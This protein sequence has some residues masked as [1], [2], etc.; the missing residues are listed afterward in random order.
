MR[1]TVRLLSYL[2]GLALACVLA[3]AVLIVWRVPERTPAVEKP[4]VMR[5]AD[6]GFSSRLLGRNDLMAAL[7]GQPVSLSLTGDEIDAV[8]QDLAR[9]MLAGAGDVS[10]DDGE[11]AVILSM[12]LKRTPLRV[13]AFRGEWLNLRAQVRAE[14][15][16]LPRLVSVRLGRLPVPPWLALWASQRVV[17]HYE[18]DEV[19]DM[20]LSSVRSVR[21]SPLKAEVTALWRGDFNTRLLSM[22]V[23]TEDHER[24][25]AYQRRLADL[26]RP[27]PPGTMYRADVALPAVIRPMFEEAR[28]RSLAQVVAG[29]TAD[30]EQVAARENRAVLLV[31]AL[32]AGQVPLERLIPPSG[33]GR[34]AAL[35][36]RPRILTLQGRPDFA[37]HFLL[38]ALLANDMGGRLTD[39][40]GVYKEMMDTRR[41]H[42]GS[43]FS[44]NDL[45]ADRAGNRFGQRARQAPVALQARVAEHGDRDDFFMPAVGDLPQFLSDQDFKRLY[46]QV[47]SDAYNA[48][49]REIDRRVNALPV[50]N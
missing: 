13:L 36:S 11:A 12:P 24:L 35:P 44:F 22:L 43:G 41:D 45:A 33:G 48:V 38:S 15:E 28:Q 10:L 37:Q 31:L 1:G 26:T 29:G 40:V 39:A 19:A 49:M 46:G 16:G 5:M 4:A 32:Y 34:V 47:G 50:L 27:P 30:S 20:A 21:I 23:P 17:A 42:G 6:G 2:I 25:R 14:P 8:W 7:R 3:L 18:L 9:R